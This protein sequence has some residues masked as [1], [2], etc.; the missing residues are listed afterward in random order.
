MT[1][2]R[3]LDGKRLRTR[4]RVEGQGPDFVLVHGVSDRLE[5]WDGIVDRLKVKYRLIRL[6]IRG[7]GESDKPAGPYS[8][9]GFADDLAELTAH[10]GLRRFH[11]AGYSLGGLIAQ[12]FALKYPASVDHLVLLSTVG[13][14]NEIE[15]A[16]V[17]ER[18]RAVEQG[19]LDTHF[20]KSISRWFTDDFIKNN[21]EL[22]KQHA[23][24]NGDG[25]QTGVRAA[26]RVLCTS[27]LIE[28]L[29]RIKAPTLVVTG[30]P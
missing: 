17:E 3:Y 24:R 28:D 12:C 16:R 6:D 20:E 1:E 9:D 11:L 30:E 23:A 5:G 2:N 27:D 18:L 15:R 4:Y 25:D 13:G 7:H 14:R 10:L 8:L 22:V 21:P 19:D 26:Y 29:P